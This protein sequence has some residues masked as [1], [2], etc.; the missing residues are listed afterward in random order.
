M[1]ASY[2]I[3]GVLLFV[4]VVLSLEGLYHLWAA[5]HSA[6]AKRIAARLR[7][8][9]GGP[10]ASPL[11]IDRRDAPQQLSWLR[12]EV[13][14]QLR[15][16]RALHEHVR[17]SGT[18]R[19]LSELLLGSLLLSAAGLLAG[20]LQQWGAA[21]VALLTLLGAVLPWWWLGQRRNQHIKRLEQQLPQALDFMGRALRAGHT[22]PSAIQMVSEEMSNPIAKEFRQ[23]FDETNFG[24]SQSEALLRLAQ[25]VP[26]DDMR[27]FAVAVMMQRESGGNLTELFD[28]LAGIVRARIKLQGQVRSISAEGRMSAWVLV[29][30]PIVVSGLMSVTSPQLLSLLLTDPVGRRLV[31]G[32]LV[33]MVLGGL[34]MRRIVR[35]QV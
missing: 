34:W 4:S 11:S 21:A 23:L 32:A 27:Y 14:A 1:D 17:T 7:F 3:M 8:L 13:L 5:K 12:S 10:A 15:L 18:G 30:M 9:D 6:E 19:T 35:I 29:L 28:K 24:M 20:L 22:L 16:V 25:R 31:A 2:F 33:L 26:L